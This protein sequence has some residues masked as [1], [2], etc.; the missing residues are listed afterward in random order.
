[1]LFLKA[2]HDKALQHEVLHDKISHALSFL[3]ERQQKIVQLKDYTDEPVQSSAM[4]LEMGISTNRIN[5]LRRKA[6]S[7][8]RDNKTLQE[9]VHPNE[10]PEDTLIIEERPYHSILPAHQFVI[11]ITL[12]DGMAAP[13]ERK[14]IVNQFHEYLESIDGINHVGKWNDPSPVDI[15]YQIFT[16]KDKKP[17]LYAKIYCS[18]KEIYERL[19][20]FSPILTHFAEPSHIAR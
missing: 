11:D 16:L 8:L 7:K 10:L 9:W 12:K 20:E 2:E 19:A 18:D 17:G 3:T 5:E 15:K 4:A 1:M 13:N 14:N 6:L